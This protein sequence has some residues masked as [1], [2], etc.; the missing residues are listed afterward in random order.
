MK[1]WRCQG[2]VWW[3]A[4]FPK[5]VLGEGERDVGAGDNQVPRTFLAQ[6]WKS[7]LR[8]WHLACT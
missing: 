1:S 5:T 8:P 4:V 6:A 7:L 3:L 2:V